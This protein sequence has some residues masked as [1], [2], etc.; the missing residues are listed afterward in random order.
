MEVEFN[1]KLIKMKNGKVI[2]V[3]K[4]ICEKIKDWEYVNVKIKKLV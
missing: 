1:C 4:Q 2:W 3:P